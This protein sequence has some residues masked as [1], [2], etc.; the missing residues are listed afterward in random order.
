ML[1]NSKKK[2]MLAT[3]GLL[4]ALI[5]TGLI[6]ASAGTNRDFYDMTIRSRGRT[7]QLRG[8]AKETDKQYS[9]VKVT[10]MSGTDE[11]DTKF[12]INDTL[13]A[14]AWKSIGSSDT[15]W[16]KLNYSNCGEPG[17]GVNMFLMACN[18]HWATGTGTIAGTVDY[19]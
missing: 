15:S 16:H 1:K 17:V 18:S 11:V 19:E 8:R 12:C 5:S 4:G 2:K 9:W 6:T 10:S 14:T 3:I 13:D 7:S